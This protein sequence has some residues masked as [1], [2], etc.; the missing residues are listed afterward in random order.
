MIHAAIA[1]VAALTGAPYATI[2]AGTHRVMVREIGLFLNAATASSVALVRPSNTPVASGV[3]LAV[4]GDVNAI[5]PVTS[6]AATWGTAPT[7]G[8]QYMRRAVIPA[9]IGNGL[10]WSFAF[11]DLIIPISGFLVLWN[12]GATTGSVLN[13]YVSAEEE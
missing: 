9:A 5:T 8:T 7:V 3:V 10:I 12:F 6:L 4:P 2:N 13:A 1:T 11:G